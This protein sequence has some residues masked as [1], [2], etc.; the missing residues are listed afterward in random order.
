MPQPMMPKATALWLIQN[1][2]LAFD[3][4]AEFC[5]LHLLEVQAL[6]DGDIM[7]GMAPLDPISNGQL[8]S[9]EIKR[10]EADPAARLR[11]VQSSIPQPQTRAKG[12]R[13]TPVA[14]RQDKPDGVAWLLKNHPELSD[15]QIGKLLGTTKHTIGSVR[16][17][18]HWNAQNIRPRDPV[19]L[20]LCTYLDLSNAVDAARAKLA[21]KKADEAKAQAKQSQADEREGA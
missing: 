10:C 2:A 15:A 17:R 14:K 12:A 11:M 7:P 4:I 8:T 18:S 3:Q 16:D 19:D 13:Y 5:G 20:G 1:T 6:A 21:S 9:E